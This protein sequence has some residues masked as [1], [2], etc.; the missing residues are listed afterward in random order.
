LIQ[1]LTFVTG[2]IAR[3]ASINTGNMRVPIPATMRLQG[4]EADVIIVCLVAVP[5]VGDGDSRITVVAKLQ[6]FIEKEVIFL[7]EPLLWFDHFKYPFSFSISPQVHSWEEK[8]NHN[9]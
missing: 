7:V 1:V 6:N 9:F 3:G 4:W 8:N 5:L 2:P